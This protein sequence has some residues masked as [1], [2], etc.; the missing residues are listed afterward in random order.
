MTVYCQNTETGEKRTIYRPYGE[1]VGLLFF[2][3][4]LADHPA[5]SIE[6]K[7]AE[8]RARGLFIWEQDANGF[9]LAGSK[10]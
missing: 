4:S 3:L 6:Y 7:A 9:L 8:S 1:S 5:Y 2:A 10:P